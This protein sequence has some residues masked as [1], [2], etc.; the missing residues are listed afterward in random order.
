MKKIQ[1]TSKF[2]RILFQIVF[3]TL[4][5]LYLI[6]WMNGGEAIVWGTKS[7]LALYPFPRVLGLSYVLTTKTLIFGMLTSLITLLPKMFLFYFLIMLFRSYE[8]GNIFSLENVMTIKKVGIMLIVTQV[9]NVIFDVLISLVMTMNNPP[10]YHMIGLH[11]ATN[12]LG[13]ALIGAV[14][15][16]VSWIMAEGYKLHVD[17]ELTV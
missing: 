9:A 17:Q 14:I 10:G 12:N 5:A 16:L 13:I 4:P 15:I 11:L 6:S 3:F 1:Q 8:R 2:F 7:S